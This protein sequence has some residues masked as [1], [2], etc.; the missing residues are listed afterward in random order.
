MPVAPKRDNL[1]CWHIDPQSSK[2]NAPAEKEVLF[3]LKL[4]RCW[5]SPNQHSPVLKGSSNE[6]YNSALEKQDI[7][8]SCPRSIQ[9]A[10][11]GYI[12]S[13]NS[14]KS[15]SAAKVQVRI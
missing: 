7:V 5:S 10:V 11:V 13:A 12:F 1:V 6:S 8:H 2:Q 4:T 9:H 3:A 14:L 15:Q